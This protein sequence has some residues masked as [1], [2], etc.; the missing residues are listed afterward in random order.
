[1]SLNK[2]RKLYENY[3]SVIGDTKFTFREIDVIAC[4]L[5]NRGEKKI[6]SLLL[7]SPRTVGTHLHNIML[8][9]GQ[10]SRE[11]VIDF[12][13][14]S[15]KMLYIKEYYLQILVQSSFEQQ[16]IKIGKTINRKVIDCSINISQLSAHEK[17]QL[18][19]ISTHLKLVNINLIKD[20]GDRDKCKYNINFIKSKFVPKEE[21]GDIFLLLDKSPS[22]EGDFEAVDYIDFCRDK[23]YYA[24]F[25][26]LLE[27][28]LQDQ[29]IKSISQEFFLE[30]KAV[31]SSWEGGEINQE[32]GG[33][34]VSAYKKEYISKNILILVVALALCIAVYLGGK[35]NITFGSDDDGG[36]HSE[37]SLPQDGVLLSRGK[38]ISHI[39]KS[40]AS[41]SGIQTVALVGIGGVG[42]STIARKYARELNPQ[43]IWEINAESRVTL[44]LSLKQIAYAI[45]STENKKNELDRILEIKDVSERES[46]LFMF[47]KEKAKS[48]PGWL[49][50]YDNVKTFK[51]I[52][53]FYPRDS[54]IWGDGKILITTNDNNIIHNE[55]LS[56]ENVIQINELSKKEKFDLFGSILG[57]E[58]SKKYNIVY[59]KCLEEVPPFPLDVSIAAHYIK[60]THIRCEQYSKYSSSN[61]ENFRSAQRNILNDVGGYSKTRY[62]II[63]LP[64][65][66]M[67]KKSPD[68]RDLLFMISVIASNDIPKRLLVS[69]KEDIV[70]DEFLYE[71]KKFSLVTKDLIEDENLGQLF[72]IHGSTQDVIFTY[73]VNSLQSAVKPEKLHNILIFL[74]NYLSEILEKHDTP[75][76]QSLVPHIESLLS[77]SRLFDNQ[78]MARLSSKLGLCYFYLGRYEKAKKIY[79]ATLKMYER[80]KKSKKIDI[81]QA[82]VLARLGSVY[83]NT[84]DFQKAKEYLQRALEI[85]KIYYDENHIE[86]GWISTILGSVYRSTGDYEKAKQLIKN[87]YR[88]HTQHYGD[89]HKKVIWS[90]SYLGQVYKNTG[91]YDEAKRLLEKTLATYEKEFGENHTQTAWIL[92]HLAS[93]YR[94]IG[95]LNKAKDCLVRT[96][97]IY[98]HQRGENS[99]EYAWS[100]IHLSAVYRDLDNADGSIELLKKSLEFYN[101][102]LEPNHVFQGWVKYHLGS[103]YRRTGEWTKAIEFLQ[104]ALEISEIYYGKNHVKSAKILNGLGKAFMGNKN[105][106]DAQ[107]YLERSLKIYSDNNHYNRY[108]SYESIGNFYNEIYRTQGGGRSAK[109]KS[110]DN[111]HKALIIIENYF[112]ADSIHTIRIKAKIENLGV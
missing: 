10:S 81:N 29:E 72:S 68:F 109:E 38:I 63:A 69:Y 73:F 103:A 65:E 89:G 100:N 14:K 47:L 42:K 45:V 48:H 3:L 97:K 17:G 78:D 105:F 28:I 31:K 61:N 101:N 102:N 57:K 88:I 59:E 62:D 24:A 43:I 54:T 44:A 107:K 35:K 20:G 27:R 19:N 94:S 32:E 30:Y 64:I 83:R 52:D 11:H 4:I 108:K 46:S 84:A 16:L 66:H 25:F 53:K 104:D 79:N 1:M 91:N 86:M 37:L 76:I 13:E 34:K 67:V 41:Q 96:I 21:C 74:E 36:L 87:G 33:G 22:E 55:N 75:K 2:K 18:S 5:H 71:L 80:E 95:Y 6:A 9:L 7:I 50:I 8:K 112:P 51:D 98:K 49:I 92:V 82:G 12:I 93:V 85:Y 70:V 110:Y 60:E 111:F 58:G 26:T 40:F 39:K 90:S 106:E 15:G 56:V 23:G 99:F 77:H